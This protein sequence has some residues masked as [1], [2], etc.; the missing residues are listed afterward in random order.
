M[1]SIAGIAG[2]E[3]KGFKGPRVTLPGLIRPGKYRSS[4]IRM[5]GKFPFTPVCE[6]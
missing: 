2:T 1:Q 5:A 3:K 6:G 4:S